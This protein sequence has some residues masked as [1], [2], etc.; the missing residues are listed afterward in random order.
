MATNTTTAEK[1]DKQ[2][3]WDNREIGVFWRREA[4]S[5]GAKY[6]SGVIN[7]KSLGLDKDIQVIGFPN[8]SKS[9]DTHPDIRLYISEAKT[10]TNPA[11]T[12]PTKPVKTVR[13]PAPVAAP[14]PEPPADASVTDDELL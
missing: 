4:K 11:A 3:E 6:L 9:K 7:L 5:N 13:P 12:A 1:T 10:G 2:K 14:A 8:K